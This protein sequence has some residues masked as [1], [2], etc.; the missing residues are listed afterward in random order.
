MKMDESGCCEAVDG[1]QHIGNS[2]T[3]QSLTENPSERQVSDRVAHYFDGSFASETLLNALQQ[4]FAQQLSGKTN[5]PDMAPSAVAEKLCNSQIP[6]QPIAPEAYTEL[7]NRDVVA[8]MTNVA[9]PAFIGHMTTPMP[10]FIPP[11]QQFLSQANQNVVKVKTAKSATFLER[12][13]LACCIGSFFR[14]SLRGTPT[15]FNIHNTCTAL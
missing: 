6:P 8:H 13:V 2:L 3:G 5:L 12:Q 4:G 10:G 14:P 15:L 1:S 7:L 9:E 11:L